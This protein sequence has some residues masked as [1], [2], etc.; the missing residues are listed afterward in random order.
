MNLD[1]NKEPEKEPQKFF[2]IKFIEDLKQALN[3]ANKK[4]ENMEDIEL[5]QEEELNFEKEEFKFL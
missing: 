2:I 4:S 1:L 5:S 3:N